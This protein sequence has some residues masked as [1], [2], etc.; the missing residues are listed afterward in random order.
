MSDLFGLPSWRHHV[1]ALRRPHSQPPLLLPPAAW[2]QR[3][4]D[5]AQIRGW[6]HR[7]MRR[8]LRDAGHAM[9]PWRVPLPVV[10]CDECGV[11]WG[12]FLP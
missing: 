7:R 3:M 1:E 2:R 10:R 11:D 5:E 4:R 9:D 12:G 6:T 8:E